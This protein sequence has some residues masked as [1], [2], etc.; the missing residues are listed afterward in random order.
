MV[1]ALLLGEGRLVGEIVDV[2]ESGRRGEAARVY[3]V[4][5][6][7]LLEVVSIQRA[8][9]DAVEGTKGESFP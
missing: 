3:A 4:D 5:D 2:G 8:P 9:F 7:G 6:D 1:E